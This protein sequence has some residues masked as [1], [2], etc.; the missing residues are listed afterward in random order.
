[1]PFCGITRPVRESWRI[2][3]LCERAGCHCDDDDV[4]CIQNAAAIVA[5]QEGFACAESVHEGG[6]LTAAGGSMAA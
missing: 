3:E 1:M 5:A 4:P 6:V 2:H